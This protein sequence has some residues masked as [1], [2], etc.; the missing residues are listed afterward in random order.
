MTDTTAANESMLEIAVNAAAA[1]HDLT[2]FEKVDAAVGL[3]DGYEARCRKCGR[4]AW[5]GDDGLM[6]S[7]LD[8][9]RC[10]GLKRVP[11]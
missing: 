6:Y 2:G 10:P 11:G 1:G 8:R 7:L 3:P 5:V 9:D 4:T